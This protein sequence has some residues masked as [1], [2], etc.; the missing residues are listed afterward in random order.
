MGKTKDD[1]DSYRADSCIKDFRFVEAEFDNMPIIEQ[2]AF[3][4]SMIREGAPVVCLIFTGSK[5]IHAWW[6]VNY[7]TA[8]EWTQK[9][10]QKLFPEFLTP[11]GV[12]SACKNEARLSRLPGHFRA[13]KKQF[14]KLLYFNPELR[15]IAI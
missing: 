9:V 2:A 10:E 5:S 6:Q 15:E 12:D 8:D 13:D 7:T 4:M 1:K 3:W 11:L 14:Q